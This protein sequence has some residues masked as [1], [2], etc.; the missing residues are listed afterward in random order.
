MERASEKY[1]ALKGADRLTEICFQ[2]PAGWE[3]D[4]LFQGSVD[5]VRTNGFTDNLNSQ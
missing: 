1:S 5:A 2:S 4:F 3:V